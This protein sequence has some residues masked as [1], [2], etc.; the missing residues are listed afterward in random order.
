MASPQDEAAMRL[1]LDQAHNAWL[2][3]EG[4]VGAVVVPGE[5]DLADQVRVRGL[6]PVE[7]AE[8]RAEAHH[9]ALAADAGDLQDVDLLGHC[10]LA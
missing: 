9:A 7:I 4:P 5:G 1:A 8:R 6:E 2:V 10:G 3:G